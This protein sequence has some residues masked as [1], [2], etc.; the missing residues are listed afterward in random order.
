MK[1]DFDIAVIGG[2]AGGLFAAS[3][4]NGLGAKVCLIEKKRLGGDCTW[5][6]CMPSK[7]LLKSAAVA[8]LFKRYHE[9]GINLSG[10]FKLD[11]SGVMPHV[12]D[13]VQEIATHHPAEVFEKRGI[14]VVFGTPS[15][16]VKD[17]I[18]VGER[19]IKSRKF[20]LCTGSHPVIPPIEGLKEINYLTNEN[21]FD[22]KQLPESL[23]VLGGGPIGIEL[24]QALNRL[25]VSVYIVEM[26]PRILFREDSDAAVVLENKL[27]SEGIHI[28]TGKKAIKFTAGKGKIIVTLEDN[29]KKQ[30]QLS[31]ENVLVA[32]GR[33]PNLEGL[34]LERAAV[35]YSQA[36]IKVNSYLQTTNQDIFACGDIAGPYMFSHMASYQAQVC[37][38][39]ALFKSIAWQ[40]ADYTN[41]SWAT[42]TDPELAHLGLTEEEARTK[43]KDIKIYKTGYASCDRA[44]TDLE[45][46][47]LVKVI[48]DKKG[49]ILGAHIAGTNAGELIHEFILAKSLKVPLEKLSWPIF[50]YPVLS[51]LV[52]KTAVKPLLEKAGRPFVKFLIKLLKSK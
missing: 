5:F 20:I 47:G 43:Y 15:F 2:G 48:T 38:R 36:G 44:I 18:E 21:V 27:K 35:A 37:A 7:A 19:K 31:A 10:N 9:F 34:N 4:A 13:V 32:A 12:Q 40:K 29:D 45:K 26:M 24:S 22:L 17:T 52:K 51:E 30:E 3:V 28:L 16:A 49:Y 25:G 8:N 23:I 6:G 39:N 1:Y 41:I 46:D 11:T 42:F 33:A 14:K 50:I